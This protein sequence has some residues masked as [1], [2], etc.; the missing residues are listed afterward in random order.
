[1]LDY[2]KGNRPASGCFPRS[3][4]RTHDPQPPLAVPGSGRSRS[5]SI[6][7]SALTRSVCGMV[8]P[9]AFAVLRLITRE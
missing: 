9:N 7:L 5:Y 2:T 6:T 8:R 4:M 3:P 1:M